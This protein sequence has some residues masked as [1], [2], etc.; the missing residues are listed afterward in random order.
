MKISTITF[1]LICVA[2][3][4]Q[5]KGSFTDSRDG[6]KYK[7]V[8]IGEQTWMAEN[9]DYHGDD[10]FLGLCYG[11]EPKKKIKKPENCQKY[12]RLYDWNEAMK[13]CPKGWHLPT[14]R[15]FE[16]LGY[17]G[18]VAG[19]EK[20]AGKKLKAKSG[21]NEYDFSRKNPKAPK[22]KWTEENTDNRGRVT[23][24]KYDKC[25]TDEFGFSALPGGAGL[26]NGSFGSVGNSGF[27]WSS[28][29]L[30]SSRAYVLNM[31]Y[32]DESVD[33]HENGEVKSFLFSVRCL[34]D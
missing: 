14:K 19:G 15:E 3:F 21:W 29:E 33:L 22:C 12:G 2:A 16:V 25:S 5:Q 30:N 18:G 32:V 31:S 27:W 23:V 28:T 9:L 34:Q 17:V 11:D 26:P 20:V 4:A 8:K 24:T 6:K 10:G 7:T 13:A 1:L